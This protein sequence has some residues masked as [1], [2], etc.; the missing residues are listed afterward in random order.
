MNTWLQDCDMNYGALFGEQGSEGAEALTSKKQ[1]TMDIFA[2]AT[3]HVDSP[4]ET[5]AIDE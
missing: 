3:V 5:P 4:E 1:I 2:I